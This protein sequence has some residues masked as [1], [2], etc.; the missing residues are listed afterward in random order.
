MEHVSIYRRFRPDTFDKVVGQDHIVRILTNQIKSGRVSHAY[1]FT[2]TRGT[3]KTSCAKIFAKAVNCLSPVNGS[4]CGRCAS[5]VSIEKGSIDVIEIDAASN[6]RVEE[7][8]DL[9]ENAF[10]RPMEAKYKVYI[11]DEVHMLTGPAFNALLKTLEE[12]PAHVIFILATTE[13]Q[14]LPQTV[15]SR[16]MRFDF[17]LVEMNVL[18]SLLKRIFDEMKVKYEEEA[19]RLI[20]VT[21]EGSVRDTLSAADLCLSYGEKKLTED[22]VTEI[23]CATSFTALDNLAKSILDGDVSNALRNAAAILKSGKTNAA[24]DLARYFANLITVKNVKDA[25][26]DIG[27]EQTKALLRR[28]EQYSNFSIARA[29]DIFT[30]LESVMRYSTQPIIM[31][32][33]AIVKACEVTAEQSVDGLN[34]RIRRLEKKLEEVEKNGVKVTPAPI[35]EEVPAV[36]HVEPPVKKE[37]GKTLLSALSGLKQTD[38]EL[39]FEDNKPKEEEDVFR[40]LDVWAKVRAKLA[41]RQES[42]IESAAS[43]VE[44]GLSISGTNFYLRTNE[45]FTLEFFNR[46]QYKKMLQDL[47]REELGKEFVFIC[48]AAPAP[49]EIAAESKL[50]LNKLF[51]NNVK[52]KK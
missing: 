51:D 43:S 29:M 2:G 15:L 34:E 42:L 23:L 3:G 45:K 22:D 27:E 31:L 32:E 25:K 52:F 33:A 30:S 19:L 18:V 50:A 8:R 38:A 21:G 48:E 6:N 5:C 20:A 40:A 28:C 14:K 46:P 26:L 13:V 36:K 35:K 4:P 11:V 39:I 37:E 41:E 1:L 44:S 24:R 49:N 47:I 17:R 7:V 12:P 16:C 9:K 10:Y